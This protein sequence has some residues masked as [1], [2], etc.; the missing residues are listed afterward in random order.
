FSEVEQI[1]SVTSPYD[2]MVD[3]S[4]SDD[5]STAII[6]AQ[7][8]VQMFDV[9]DDSRD[10]LEAVAA[11]LQEE[12]P[13]GAQVHLGGEAFTDNVPSP[14]VLEAVVVVLALVFV[15]LLFRSVKTAVVPLL[16]ALVRVAPMELLLPAATGSVHIMA[17]APMLAL[18]LVLVGGID[19]ALFLV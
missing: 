13:A 16:T 11:D 18:M 5:G 15:F 17:A 8:S 3:G 9:T 6:V 2:G 4:I 7:Y 12:P 19:W 1:D 10:G 14:S